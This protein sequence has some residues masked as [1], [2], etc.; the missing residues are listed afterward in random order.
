MLE[1]IA[2]LLAVDEDTLRTA[3]TRRNM[4]V[5][6]QSAS[7]MLTGLIG[8]WTRVPNSFESIRGGGY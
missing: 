6:E 3:L 2:A 1:D 7:N 8:S 5:Y 4:K